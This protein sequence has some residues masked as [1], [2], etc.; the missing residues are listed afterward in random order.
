MTPQKLV[1]PTR[2]SI[3]A[4]RW[5]SGVGATPS[6]RPELTTDVRTLAGRRAMKSRVWE[7]QSCCGYVRTVVVVAFVV[8]A[9]DIDKC[10]SGP[11]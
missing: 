9:V 2:R 1:Y 4:Q 7:Q 3:Y 6:E 10:G 8:A 5:Q 11:G